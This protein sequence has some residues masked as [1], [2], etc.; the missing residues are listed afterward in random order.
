MERKFETVGGAHPLNERLC[1]RPIEP[2][3]RKPR[4]REKSSK[5]YGACHGP[6]LRHVRP[7][8]RRKDDPLNAMRRIGGRKRVGRWLQVSDL[9]VV[10]TPM[11]RKRVDVRVEVSQRRQTTSLHGQGK[12]DGPGGERTLFQ[13]AD[14]IGE[15]R[16]AGL[17]EGG[18][19]RGFAASSCRRHQHATVTERHDAG[20]NAEQARA[21]VHGDRPHQHLQRG[22]RTP[23]PVAPC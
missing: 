2:V 17:Y 23:D 6:K 10:L 20:V 9:Q 19:Q 18:G 4:F 21:V 15:I 1:L 22:H 12:R 3:G 8:V 11:D 16:C 7:V 13:N 5:R 14:L